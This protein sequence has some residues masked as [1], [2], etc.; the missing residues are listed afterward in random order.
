MLLLPVLVTVPVKVL[1]LM[2]SV[3]VSPVAKVP[4]TLPVTGKV[5]CPDLDIGNVKRWRPKTIQDW[6]DSQKKG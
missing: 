2:V 4:V 3:T 5:P 6:I 1:L